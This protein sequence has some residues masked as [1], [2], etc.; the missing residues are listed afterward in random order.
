MK[1]CTIQSGLLEGIQDWVSEDTLPNSDLYLHTWKIKGNFEKFKEVKQKYKNFR[2]ITIT[3]EKYSEKFLSLLPSFSHGLM[4]LSDSFYQNQALKKFAGLYS[5]YKAVQSVPTIEKYDVVLKTHFHLLNFNWN[6]PQALDNN[7]LPYA[8]NARQCYPLLENY[9]A[10]ECVY[11]RTTYKSYNQRIFYT[12]PQVIKKIFSKDENLFATT[13]GICFDA[14]YRRTG[15]L[16]FE[17][18]LLWQELFN[19]H[20]IPILADGS[21]LEA[22]ATN[23]APDMTFRYLEQVEV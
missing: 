20:D 3:G 2:S 10:F 8:V 7:H 4:N 16:G 15:T 19:L 5:F 17:G 1:L 21:I 9:K 11:A 14:L 22:P 23:G 12:S 18:D 6:V 13:V